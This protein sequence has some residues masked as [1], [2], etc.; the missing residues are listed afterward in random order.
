MVIHGQLETLLDNPITTLR[1]LI[2]MVIIYGGLSLTIALLLRN[3]RRVTALVVFGFVLAQGGLWYYRN[4][5]VDSFFSLR[6]LL[7][8]VGMFL[9]AF[10]IAWIASTLPEK[11]PTISRPAI[12]PLLGIVIV[13]MISIPVMVPPVESP[14]PWPQ[15][16]RMFS[17]NPDKPNVLL[18]TLDTVRPDHL[19]AYN[20]DA[21]LT[22]NLDMIADEGILYLRAVSQAPITPVSHASILTGVYPPKHNLRNF[23]YDNQLSRE[24]LL[25]SEIL[26]E[27]GYLTGA[28][29]A[30]T[31]LH[32][33]FGLDRGFDLYHY[34]A[35]SETYLFAGF[36]RSLLPTV[37]QVSGLVK[38]RTAYRSGVEQTD[39]TLLWLDKYRDVP[40]FLWLHYFDAH[41]P[42]FP[43]QESKKP[44]RHPGRESHDLSGRDFDYD[45]EIVGLDL[46][47][48]RIIDRL[49]KHD[50]LDETII[51]VISDHGE[52]LGEHNYIG[53][54]KRIYDEQL[55]LVLFLRYPERIRGGQVVSI[56]V[57]SID[58]A[59][60]ILEL[61]DIQV[62]PGMD[63]LSLLPLVETG[64]NSQHRLAY[65]ETFAPNEQDQHLVSVNDG[66]YKLIRSLGGENWLYDVAED[67]GENRNLS[68]ER[69][70]EMT[71]LGT[72]LDSYISDGVQVK[73]EEK[74]SIDLDEE[75]REKLQALG[76]I[77]N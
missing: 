16:P 71:R 75:I 21:I 8:I 70:V 31:T 48:G 54:T 15:T 46:Q 30:S 11:L 22:P 29:I 58:L 6:S 14:G 67:P 40:F 18:I 63:G 73:D 41:D 9:A 32:P 62:P 66:R 5:L 34:V 13:A 19:G 23:E 36:G 25:L 61:L 37:L 1:S 7:P 59:P 12:A 26:S 69:P 24:N 38:D 65:S 55:R 27:S 28:I 39:D 4:E 35:S 68:D 57:R 42:Y 45:S 60:T 77:D 33:L 44:E 43:D 64:E 52:G 17:K 56:Q 10:V 72:L 74:D 51:A 2:W 3:G 47:I 76:Y 20:Y 49:R 53:H 50:I